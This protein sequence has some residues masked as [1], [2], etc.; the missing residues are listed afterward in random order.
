MQ[1]YRMLIQ[2]SCLARLMNVLDKPDTRP[3]VVVA[4]Y[5]DNDKFRRFLVYQPD[6]A[7]GAVC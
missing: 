6:K 4:Y 2:A 3:F 7:S 1:I 5:F